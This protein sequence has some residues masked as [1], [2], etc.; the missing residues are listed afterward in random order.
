MKICLNFVKIRPFAH[1]Y[2]LNG[3]CYLHNQVYVA[4]NLCKISL[5]LFNLI[6]NLHFFV[7]CHLS[8]T[9]D[10]MFV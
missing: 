8:T 1:V 2:I 7:F 9:S 5:D 4:S 10:E 6:I 3:R